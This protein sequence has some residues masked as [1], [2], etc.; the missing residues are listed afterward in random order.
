[1][2]EN[3]CFTAFRITGIFDPD[4]VTSL[5]GIQ[6]TRQWKIGDKRR[7]GTEYDFASW[8]CSRCDEYDVYTENQMHKTIEP[9]LDKIDILN[10]IKANN[11]VSF[12]IAV[13]PTLYTDITT[14]ALAPSLKVIDFCH[15]TRTEIDIDLYIFEQYDELPY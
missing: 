5:L 13:V 4:M 1:M 7:N 15:A 6:P 2:K 14:P 11:A 12:T 9:L 8:E 3:T 10:Q